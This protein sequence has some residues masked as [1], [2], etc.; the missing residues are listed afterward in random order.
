M[1]G[2][3]IRAKPPFADDAQV[4]V[5]AARRDDRVGGGAELARGRVLDPD[6]HREAARHLAMD[7]TLGS[8]RADRGPGEQISEVVAHDRVEQLGRAGNAELVHRAEQ[9]ARA[10]EPER[11]VAAREAR[12][13]DES[14]P[15]ERASQLP[16]SRGSLIIPFQPSV[17][18][19]FSK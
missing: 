10:F 2:V 7:L 5:R 11:E 17:V 14:L 4:A 12:V 19:G 8:A 9:L 3:S 1:P 6:R 13:V 16:S 15:A 18:R